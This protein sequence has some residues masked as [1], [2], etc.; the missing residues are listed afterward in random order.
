MFCNFFIVQCVD[1]FRLKN[2]EKIWY[3]YINSNLFRFLNYE[4]KFASI[5]LLI[6]IFL[7]G[8]VLVPNFAFSAAPQTIGYEGFL[9]NTSGVAQTGVHTVRIRMYDAA[10]GGILLYDETHAGVSVNN[11]FFALQI[12]SGVFNGGAVNEIA[13][14]PFDQQYY[15]TLEVSTLG[16]GEMAP[17]IAINA[18]AY[19]YTAYGLVAQA[20]D[21]VNNLNAGEVYFNTASSTLKVYNGASWDTLST[22]GGIT[23]FNGR[24]GDVISE[25][26]DYTTDQI[27][28]ATSL[29]YTDARSRSAL[30]GVNGIVFSTTTGVI[31]DSF[32]AGTGL[33]RVGNEFSLND[34][35]VS[36]GLYGSSTTIPNFIVDAQGRLVAASSSALSV[37]L[38]TD[39]TGNY[40]A[41]VADAG[42]SRLVITGS[43]VEN[44]ALT[45]D[46]A[47]GAIDA[48]RLASDAVTNAKIANN[49]ID[50]TKIAL[51][52]DTAG[53]MMY[54][55]GTDWVRLA[56]G[57]AGQTLQT[58]GG[59]TA[60]TWVTAAAVNLYTTNG[61]LTGAR[62]I[63]T[64][65]NALTI[66]GTGDIV[67][68]DSGALTLGSNLTV[69]GSTITGAGALTLNS[70]NATALN[71]DSGTTGALNIGTGANAKTITLGNTTGA[72]SLV[73]NAGTGNI[74]IGGTAV[75]RTLNFGTGAGVVQ[76]INI[77]GTGA[78]VIGIGNTQTGGSV[79]IGAAM[80]TGAITIGGTGATTLNL[81]SGTGNI[82][83]QA[84]GTGTTN[85]VQIGAGGAGSATPDL[86]VMDVKSTSGDPA[87]TNGA[88]Y[89]NSNTSKFRC[90]QGGAWTDC[91]STSGNNSYFKAKN[92]D[93]SA[94][95]NT[96]LANDS[97]LN[98][99]V[100][101]GETWAVNYELYITNNNSAQPDLKMAI[102][103]ASGW[104]CSFQMSGLDTGGSNFDQVVTTDCDNI[105]N[106]LVNGVVTGD[107][108]AG[109][110]VHILG[111]ITASTA[112]TVRLQFA[113]NT[114]SVNPLTIKA[115]S[116]VQAFKTA[117]SDVAEIY[118]STEPLGPGTVVSIDPEI[119]TQVI[120]SSGVDDATVLGVV[121]TRPGLILGDS[122][123]PAPGT[124]PTFIALS[125]RVPVMVS[126]ENGP[127]KIGDYL[128]NSSLPGMAM[129]A[130]N[131]N[132]ILGQALSAFD[133]DTVGQVL[134][135]VKNFTIGGDSVALEKI[136][137]QANDD[138]SDSGLS[139]LLS[140]IQDEAPH[141][142][143]E[144]ITQKISSGTQLV[145][146]FVAA[147]VTAIRG[148]FDELFAKKIHTEEICVKKLDGTEFCAN[149][150]DL[151]GMVHNDGAPSHDDASESAPT[152]EPVEV[153]EPEVPVSNPE[154]ETV[155]ESGVESEPQPAEDIQP[156]P[157]PEPLAEPV[158]SPEPAPETPSAPE[159][160]ETS[161]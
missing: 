125:G 17:R 10:G 156:E 23:S 56:L 106:T 77:G 94:T 45:I 13:D 152:T 129:R 62:T 143:V 35:A 105:P 103:G 50:G 127:I 115:G 66:D 46:V 159:S 6:S 148:Y 28:E 49:A 123:S 53:D 11:G 38:G 78:N 126:A 92:A 160:E 155:T 132:H 133:G 131:N 141:N 27:T 135:F 70:G 104:T 24:T 107:N 2:Q 121:S 158:E 91:I 84:A 102:L 33:G 83:L 87:G 34:T 89:Y 153:V 59:A 55:N 116:F 9:T 99:P 95:S 25:V 138:G 150:D 68:A 151:Q 40:V 22:T 3:T 63:T 128:T 69:N 161:N 15:F 157:P 145:S 98:F 75:A 136:T 80:T 32:T 139:S 21:P 44:A 37:V 109:I 71:V 57:T 134:M 43:G 122:K 142:A 86:L 39:T 8:S 36:A 72:T 88:M 137:P 130:Q 74:D 101:A 19:A 18:T 26:G 54:Y 64:G 5:L 73:F 29:Y 76:T 120:K 7:G 60:P 140:V 113:Q 108:G 100:A 81:Q 58:N 118:Y 30:S 65:G 61:T 41:T 110:N 47:A 93:Q 52:S 79:N 31:D 16:T 90:Y 117:G 48:T 124:I 111:T 144:L 114:S 85:N 82:N 42:S 20:T 67:F 147:R 12:G 112:G 51:G 149:G 119:P 1:K 97:D 96:T 4:K 146:N 154:P 14:L